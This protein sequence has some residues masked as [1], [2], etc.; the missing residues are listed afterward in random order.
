MMAYTVS[1]VSLTEVISTIVVVKAT[2]LRTAPIIILKL[3]TALHANK[4]L[5]RVNK[6]VPLF[7][8][9]RNQ[10]AVVKCVDVSFMGSSVLWPTSLKKR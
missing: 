3:K 5:R 9:G 10:T 4:V 7:P 2:T 6:D 1:Q 8:Y